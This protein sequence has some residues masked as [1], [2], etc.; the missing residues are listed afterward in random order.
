MEI[1]E[2]PSGELTVEQ[3]ASPEFDSRFLPSQVEVPDF[4]FTEN[5][6]WARLNLRNESELTENWL[7][8]AGFQNLQYV[9]LFVQVED[10]EG[11]SVK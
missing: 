11:F 1:L 3:V 4:G 10:G 2:D 9:D 6:Y 8:E 5:V 7:L